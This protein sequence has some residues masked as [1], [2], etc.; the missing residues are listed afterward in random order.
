MQTDIALILNKISSLLD[1]QGYQSYAVGGL[2]R[3][4]F[5]G[6]ETNDLDIAINGSAIDIANEVAKAMK[7]KF[8]LLDDVNGIARVVVSEGE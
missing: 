3:D 7:G 1:R 8:V 5:L 6:N 2:I 4:W